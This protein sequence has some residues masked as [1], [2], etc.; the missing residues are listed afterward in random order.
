[1]S[2]LGALLVLTHRPVQG[3][4]RPCER[5]ESYGSLAPPKELVPTGRLRNEIRE[6]FQLDCQVDVIDH[7]MR[8]DLQD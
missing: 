8:R 3:N 7:H 6:I 5:H 4:P 2:R 1:M